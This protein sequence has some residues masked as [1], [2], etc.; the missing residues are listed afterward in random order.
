ME[1]T[2]VAGKIQVSDDIYNGLKNQFVLEGHGPVEVKGKGA[3][4]TWFLVRPVA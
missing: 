4:R 1:S 2:G 3:L